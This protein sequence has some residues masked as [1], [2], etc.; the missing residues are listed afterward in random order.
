LAGWGYN[1]PYNP[2]PVYF[3]DS[4]RS[5]ENELEVENEECLS[6]REW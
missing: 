2:K 5:D 1:Y 3:T 4:L 6:L